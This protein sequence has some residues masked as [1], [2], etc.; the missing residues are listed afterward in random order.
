MVMLAVV[1]K[2]NV[3]GSGTGKK[4]AHYATEWAV[5]HVAARLL[6]IES[7]GQELSTTVLIS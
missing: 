2:G 1:I 3:R 5:T 7:S 6:L 4:A